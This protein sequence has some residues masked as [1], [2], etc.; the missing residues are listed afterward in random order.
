M[1]SARCHVTQRDGLACASY[2]TT[3]FWSAAMREIQ[4]LL[5]V[6]LAPQLIADRNREALRRK[7][8]SLVLQDK[9]R[10]S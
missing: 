9:E 5:L 10:A 3:P 2:R 6:L 4:Y 8:A 1:T 7:C